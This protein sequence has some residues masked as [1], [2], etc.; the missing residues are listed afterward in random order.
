MKIKRSG[1]HKSE[2]CLRC[3]FFLP[4]LLIPRNYAVGSKL[5]NIAKVK[6]SVLK[7]CGVRIM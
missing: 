2:I 5:L 7:E 6:S 1:E 4:Q 3:L